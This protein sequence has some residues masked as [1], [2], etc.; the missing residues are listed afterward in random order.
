MFACTQPG[1][2]ETFPTDDE[3]A[4]HLTDAHDAFSDVMF[5]EVDAQ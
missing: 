2:D 3:L 5:M 1:C 4:D